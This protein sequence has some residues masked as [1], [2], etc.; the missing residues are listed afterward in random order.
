MENELLMKKII[1]VFVLGFI[2]LGAFAKKDINA[3]KQEESLPRQ[4]EVFKK[5][6]NYWNG[7]YFLKEDQLYDFYSSLSDT[8]ENL[9]NNVENRNAQIRNLKSEINS[10]DIQINTLQQDLDESLRLQNSIV[11]LGME[12]N[13]NV[14]SGFMYLLIAG[15][16][17]L[18]GFVFLLYKRSLAVMHRTKKDY[19]A[20]K[21][22]YE[23]HKKSALERYTKINMELHQTRLE[24][25]KK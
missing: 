13:K 22:E 16:F 2:V 21:K 23:A 18:A 6:L 24:L 25:K 12:I 3:W 10:R 19:N 8:I 1:A 17:V 11:F 20:L 5:N 15:V 4:Y 7:S 14:Y 9:E